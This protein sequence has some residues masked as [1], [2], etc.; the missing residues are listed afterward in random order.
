MENIS[1][2]RKEYFELSKHSV[3]QFLVLGVLL[4]GIAFALQV[5]VA[6]PAM[7]MFFVGS[8]IQK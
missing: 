1:S 4:V 2:S 5:Y 6:I 3:V 8:S 7:D